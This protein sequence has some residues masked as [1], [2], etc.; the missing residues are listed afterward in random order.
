MLQ[1]VLLRCNCG[2]RL[3]PYLYRNPRDNTGSANIAEWND[4]DY[5]PTDPL[6]SHFVKFITDPLEI[7]VSR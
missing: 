3:D 7:S 2:N 5:G 1:I 4:E 6:A